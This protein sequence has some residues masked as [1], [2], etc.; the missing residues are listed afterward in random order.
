MLLSAMFVN[1]TDGPPW[2][3]VMLGIGV[4]GMVVGFLWIRRIAAGDDDLGSSFWRSHP[5]GGHGSILPALQRPPTWRWIATRLGLVVALGSVV[6]SIA[7]PALLQRWEASLDRSLPMAAALWAIAIVAALV[8][9]AWMLRIA[10]GDADGD[11]APWRY[12]RD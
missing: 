4:L 7:G 12:R 3:A 5:R 11:A 2:Q 6:V 8:G 10:R 9:T 1:P